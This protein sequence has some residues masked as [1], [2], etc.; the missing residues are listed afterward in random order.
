MVWIADRLRESWSGPTALTETYTLTPAAFSNLNQAWNV[1]LAI[2]EMGPT[3][4]VARPVAD[5]FR[6]IATQSSAS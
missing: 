6:K 4:C 3:R 1:A 2:R 5:D